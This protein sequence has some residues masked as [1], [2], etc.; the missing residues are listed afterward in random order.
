MLAFGA[1][2]CCATSLPIAVRRI[3]A[4][5]SIPHTCRCLKRSVNAHR[6]SNRREFGCE[7]LW[8]RCLF[9]NCK[10][11]TSVPVAPGL[12]YPSSFCLSA[13]W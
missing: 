8:P 7:D 1:E 12:Q 2:L 11:A 5:R 6:F 4:C 13:N 9:E 10:P 3:A